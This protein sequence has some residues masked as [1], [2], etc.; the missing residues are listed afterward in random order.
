MNLSALAGNARIRDQLNARGG[1]LAHAYILSGP[2]G[3]G[4]HT[5]ARILTAA[6][7]CTAPDRDSC[8]CG[9]CLP[10]RKVS[11]G[12]HPDVVTVGEP[13]KPANLEAVRKARLDAYIAPNEGARKVYIFEDADDLSFQ[14]QNSMLKLLEEGPPYAAFLLLAENGGGL[15]QTVRSRCEELQLTPVSVPDA[16]AWLQE[17]FPDRAPEDLRRAGEECQGIL[18]RAVEMLT[19]PDPDAEERRKLV[20]QLADA[21]ERGSE[22]D[23]FEATMALDKKTRD[24]KSGKSRAKDQS[25]DRKTAKK[26]AV[27]EGKKDRSNLSLTLDEL[28]KELTARILQAPDRRRILKAVKVI[29]SLQEKMVFNPSSGLVSSCLCA[30]I[31]SE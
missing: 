20:K 14:C 2:R 25:Q 4:K 19:E 1:T 22:P 15:L 11:G 17:K 12:I 7:M 9:T 18:G 6:M 27:R 16:A 29:R 10:C 5:L 31:F 21:I 26:E 8:P 13:G 30:G 24:R 28:E 3:S 23:L